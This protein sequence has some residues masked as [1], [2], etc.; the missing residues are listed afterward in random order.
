MHDHDFPQKCSICG[1]NEAV[2]FVKIAVNGM[3]EERGLCSECAINHLEEMDTIQGLDMFDGK[4]VS[5]IK[6]LGEL[7]GAIETNIKTYTAHLKSENENDKTALKCPN[8]GFSYDNFKTTGYVG[9]QYCYDTFGEYIQEFV[10]EL[11]RD[12]IHHGKRPPMHD[13]I[14][15]LQNQIALLRNKLDLHIR[16]E[17]YEKAKQIKNKLDSLIGNHNET[18]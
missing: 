6:D 9:C 10:F 15:K 4:I 2:I 1:K 12:S 5:I 11:E 13:K 7:L 16:N 18:N 8:C 17:E 14:H 3:T